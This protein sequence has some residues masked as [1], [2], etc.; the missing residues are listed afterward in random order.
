MGKALEAALTGDVPGATLRAYNNASYFAWRAADWQRAFELS[1]DGV[2]LARRLGDRDLE[3]GLLQWLLGTLY[4]LGRWDEAVAMEPGLLALGRTSTEMVLLYLA[5][6]EREAALG[7]LATIEGT[8]DPAEPQSVSL[9]AWQRASVA[10]ADGRPAEALAAAEEG[11]RTRD[12]QGLASQ[13][14]T[15]SLGA[16]LEA[17][18]ALG[19][20]PKLEELLGLI[21]AEA[22]GR[23]TH[24]LRALGARF[25]ALRAAHE[26]D[27]QGA[28]TGF[29]TAELLYRET[30]FRLGVVLIEHAEWLAA[31][32]RADEAEPLLDEAR[33]IFEHLGAAPWLERVAAVRVPEAA[34]SE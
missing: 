1:S 4:M 23:L 7:R 9:V 34:L 21:E 32:G 20:E 26:G 6:G 28:A 5:R 33:E 16:A 14:V 25:A 30:P 2:A 27:V 22:P 17:A 10:L 29:A 11:F 24:A 3:E 8:L 18:A 13:H 31:E 15:G 19:D 12:T